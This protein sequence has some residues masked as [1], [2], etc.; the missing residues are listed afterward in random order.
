MTISSYNKYITAL[1]NIGIRVSVLAILC[2]TAS[3]FIYSVGWPWAESFPLDLKKLHGKVKFIAAYN[4]AISKDTFGNTKAIVADK[5]YI[6]FHPSGNTIISERYGSRGRITEYYCTYDH[7]GRMSEMDIIE[8][9]NESIDNKNV[10]MHKYDKQNREVETLNYRTGMI[11]TQRVTYKYL[12]GSN[13][14]TKHTLTKSSY[15]GSQKTIITMV[16]SNNETM[17]YDYRQ[18]FED[19]H[20]FSYTKE[21]GYLIKADTGRGFHRT[22][23]YN[24]RMDKIQSD[25]YDSRHYKGITLYDGHRNVSVQKSYINDSLYQSLFHH[26]I[27]DKTGN[28]TTDSIFKEDTLSRIMIRRIEYY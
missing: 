18:N 10:N 7:R 13:K 28:W 2:Y 24:E 23:I 5:S 19:I 20:N 12:N 15:T 21:G 17:Y 26:Y 25:Y 4:Y 22:T 14:V 9:I 1:K 6:S 27:Y 11:D 8:S 16:D 3:F